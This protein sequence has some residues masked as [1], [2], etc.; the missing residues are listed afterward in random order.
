MS[1]ELKIKLIK[2]IFRENA[3]SAY[4]ESEGGEYQHGFM[5]AVESILYFEEGKDNG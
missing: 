1:D 2:H 4:E 5:A 3:D